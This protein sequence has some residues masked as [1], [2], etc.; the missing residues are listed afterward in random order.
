MVTI[1][2]KRWIR[3]KNFILLS[4]FFVFLAISST[5]AAYY[6]NDLIK[7]LASVNNGGIV[8]ADITWESLVHSFFKNSAQLGI[9]VALYL[10][11]SMNNIEK[12]ESL[13]LF[14][15]TRT[16]NR[17]KIYLPKLYSSMFF[18]VISW[19]L[20][21]FCTLYITMVL[22]EKINLEMVL[23]SSI[24][25]LA[26]I[27]Y[28]VLFS[29]SINIIFNMPFVISCLIEIL[30]LVFSSLTLIDPIYKYTGIKFLFPKKLIKYNEI[31][32][33]ENL[34]VFLYL[35]L[36]LLIIICSIWL[37]DFVRG[38]KNDSRVNQYK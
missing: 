18:F 23:A 27:S 17:L 29:F 15:F 9:F 1:E 3:S 31:F 13:K 33:S 38:E 16:R 19:L 10:I 36:F 12:T 2:M 6:A 26:M 4:I 7:S 30:I 25:H 37:F 20:G 32:S 11:L 5:L 35:T 34:E 28:L 24:L 14:F 8:L 21:L 22:Y